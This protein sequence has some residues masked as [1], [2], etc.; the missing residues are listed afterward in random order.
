MCAR[1][2]VLVA[3]ESSGVPPA[4]EFRI[5][6]RQKFSFSRETEEVDVKPVPGLCFCTESS[7]VGF[8]DETTFAF[9]GAFRMGL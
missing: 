6:P 8:V 7:L 5:H 4:H 1:Q 2:A 9:L 3:F